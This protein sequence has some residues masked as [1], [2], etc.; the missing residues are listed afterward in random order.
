MLHTVFSA[1]DQHVE[2][3]ASVSAGISP[4]HRLHT[5]PLGHAAHRRHR[6]R[7][8]LLVCASLAGA[9]DTDVQVGAQPADV[10][11]HEAATASL[12]LWDVA[13]AGGHAHDVVHEVIPAGRC[14]RRT[15][16]AFH[17]VHNHLG[18]RR[19]AL[20]LLHHEAQRCLVALRQRRSNPGVRLDAGQ[21]DA[22]GLHRVKDAVKQVQQRG[23]HARRGCRNGGVG[24]LP[25][26]ALHVAQA[27]QD[28]KVLAHGLLVLVVVHG[29]G[30]VA[31]RKHL[32]QHDAQAPHVHLHAVVVAA[33]A[34]PGLQQLRAHV[35][36][37]AHVRGVELAGLAGAPLPSFGAPKVDQLQSRQAAFR[38]RHQNVLQLEVSVHNLHAMQKRH[39]HHHLPQKVTRHL[40]VRRVRLAVAVQGAGGDVLQHQ[41]EVRPREQQLL[42]PHHMRASHQ[43]LQLDLI[44]Y[45]L[46]L[47]VV[48]ATLDELY[49]HFLPA[50]DG[51]A[52]PH[53]RKG[54][55]PQ[56]PYG[57]EH[58]LQRLQRLMR[59]GAAAH[60]RNACLAVA[61]SYTWRR[62]ASTAPSPPASHYQPRGLG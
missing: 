41:A 31:A 50:V 13:P 36:R 48:K 23:A 10:V 1:S 46:R 6:P 37:R 30:H 47:E 16:R 39:A 4:G 18:L 32:H 49:R 60:H 51:L 35:R 33:P 14:I 56:A 28:A 27:L 11:H 42:E 62:P 53:V 59:A 29:V 19:I 43:R 2:M 3:R 26:A 57:A 38:L 40:L 52:E 22:R 55:A 54:A 45:V 61:R 20:L 21:V 8:G 5:L 7:L 12:Q 17:R 25:L 44:R 15:C 9:G 58:R 34:Q 24:V